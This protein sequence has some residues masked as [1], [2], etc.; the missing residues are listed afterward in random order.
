MALVRA[1]GIIS[2]TEMGAQHPDVREGWR[3]YKKD[4][5]ILEDYIVKTWR[6]KRPARS[7]LSS[8]CK[9]GSSSDGVKRYQSI[10]WQQVQER[11]F[12]LKAYLVHMEGTRAEIAGALI[13]RGNAVEVIGTR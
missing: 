5:R 13:K 12:H 4:Q 9:V 1:V 7:S 3:Q 8:R 11:S 2:A 10:I 6:E